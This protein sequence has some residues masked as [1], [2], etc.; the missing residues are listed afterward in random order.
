MGI[1]I[2]QIQCEFGCP[3][4]KMINVPKTLSVTYELILDDIMRPNS[5]EISPN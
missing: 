5:I 4:S 3:K 2:G 1:Y